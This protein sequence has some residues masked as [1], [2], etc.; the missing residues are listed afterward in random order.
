MYCH[1]EGSTLWSPHDG[2]RS[3]LSCRHEMKVSPEINYHLMGALRDRVNIYLTISKG[4]I[5]YSKKYFKIRVSD[6]LEIFSGAQ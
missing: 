5:L 2:M 4:N 1:H 3:F 6:I